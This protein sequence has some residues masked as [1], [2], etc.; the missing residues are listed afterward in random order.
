MVVEFV[1]L[2]DAVA[3]VREHFSGLIDEAVWWAAAADVDIDPDLFALVCAG[4][5]PFE[6][7]DDAAP[8]VWTRVGVRVLLRCG[9]PN[10]CSSER[11]QWPLEVVPAAWQWLGF[12]HDTRRLDPRSDPLWE[13]HKPLICYGGLDFDGRWRP[14]GDPSPIPCECYLPYRTS[15]EYLN[16]AIDAGSLVPD[17]LVCRPPDQPPAGAAPATLDQ[18]WTSDRLTPGPA[19]RR[20]RASPPRGRRPRPAPPNSDGAGPRRPSPG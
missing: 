4:T 14:V 3:P 8:L 18:P 17:A 9:V 19:R 2:A 13:L 10:W 5:Q 12:L 7:V 16:A 1:P 11:T 6:A 20:R 15:A